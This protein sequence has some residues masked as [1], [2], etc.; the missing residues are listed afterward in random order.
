MSEIKKITDKIIKE[1]LIEDR[2]DQDKTTDQCIKDKIINFNVVAKEDLILCGIE[3]IKNTYNIIKEHDKFKNYQLTITNHKKDGDFI[4]ANQII[5]SGFGDA[6]MIL[7]GER[8]ALNLIQHLCGIATK[9]NK[10]ISLLNNKKIKILDTR[11]TIPSLRN[12]QK[13]GVKIGGGTNHRFNLSQAILIKDNHIAICGGIKKTLKNFNNDI[14]IECDNINQVTEALNYKPKIIMLDNMEISEIKNCSTLI[15]NANLGTKIEVSGGIN[16]S[17]INKYSSLDIDY[18][19]IG[20]LTHSVNA[21][22]L[23]LEIC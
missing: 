22:D 11:K 4:N 5:C 1:S 21:S 8:V 6:N 14:E 23:S 18:I 15:R 16:L 2:F 3:I 17:N 12:I 9:T 13:Y 19:S 10:Y 7:A 20:D